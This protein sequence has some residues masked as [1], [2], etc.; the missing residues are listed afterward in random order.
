MTQLASAHALRDER[1]A[2]KPRTN[3]SVSTSPAAVAPR[4]RGSLDDPRF[5]Q[6]S[7][8]LRAFNL[9][10]RAHRLYDSSH[11][12]VLDTLDQAYDGLRSSAVTL[13][14]FDLRIERG[15]I[16]VPKLNEGHLPD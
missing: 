13:N 11:P 7:Q 8:A 12:R 6:V 2:A 10:L 9:L 16:V 3:H 4:E 15:G 1:S 14:G 5:N